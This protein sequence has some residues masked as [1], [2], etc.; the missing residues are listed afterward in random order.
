M[1]SVQPGA[2][3]PGPDVTNTHAFTFYSKRNETLLLTGSIAVYI[4]FCA[5]EVR[6]NMGCEIWRHHSLQ[7]VFFVM[8]Q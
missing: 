5:R 8:T 7:I 1:A 2:L 3:A 4:C 6:A